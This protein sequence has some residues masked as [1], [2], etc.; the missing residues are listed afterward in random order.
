MNTLLTHIK[1]GIDAFL[2]VGAL[3]IVLSP[4][5]GATV[6]DGLTAF[7]RSAVTVTVDFHAG[8]DALAATLAAAR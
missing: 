7:T 1:R 8:A 2:A 3:A 4:T 5:F 6:I